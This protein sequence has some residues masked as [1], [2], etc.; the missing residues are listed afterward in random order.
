MALIAQ[1][2][3]EQRLNRSLTANEVA[4]FPLVNAAL[5]NYVEEMIGSS[6][7]PVSPTLRYYDGG[8]QHL[9]ID[10]CSNITEVT[11][12]DENQLV[13][14]TIDPD[15]YT[16]YPANKTIKTQITARFGRFVK[17][18]NNIG[19][20]AKFSIADDTKTIAIIKRSLLEMLAAEIESNDNIARESIE[21]Y[22]V[23]YVKSET[24]DQLDRLAF[25][26]QRII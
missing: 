20:T 24:K 26:Y 5:Q 25:L 9:A 12:R 4:L 15:D 1:A 19:V 8:V 11:Y 18:Y 2:E 17:G 23:E 6:L 16:T 7:E 3:L 10:P 22:S 21:G 13:D 14:D